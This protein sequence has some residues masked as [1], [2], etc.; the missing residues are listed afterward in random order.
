MTALMSV[1]YSVWSCFLYTKQY[2]E[3]LYGKYVLVSAEWMIS[4]QH[5]WFL[6][7]EC[8]QGYPT[9]PGFHFLALITFKISAKRNFKRGNTQL[10]AVE[11]WPWLVG[12]NFLG[13]RQD[14][15]MYL[16]MKKLLMRSWNFKTF[17]Q[18]TRRLRLV[19]VLTEDTSSVSRT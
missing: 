8:G 3:I 7:C 5:F 15:E 10:R 12:S 16:L 13:L 6:T 4:R 18:L 2:P 1:I 9:P 11:V 14:Q 17:A 19:T